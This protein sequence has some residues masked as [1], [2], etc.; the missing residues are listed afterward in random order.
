MSTHNCTRSPSKRGR[1]SNPGASASTVGL[2]PEEVELEP[3][4]LP[5]GSAAPP[6]EGGAGEER[7]GR[8]RRACQ[9]SR[10]SELPHKGQTRSPESGIG[11]RGGGD[12]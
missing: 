3:W 6:E 4:E 10:D 1:T 8:H 11:T 9:T 2:P 7:A 12:T 5:E